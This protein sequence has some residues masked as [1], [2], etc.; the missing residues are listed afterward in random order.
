MMLYSQHLNVAH[1][2]G[3]GFTNW[4]ERQTK[5][6][7]KGNPQH[8]PAFQTSDCFFLIRPIGDTCSLYINITNF[9]FYC[10]VASDPK[11]VHHNVLVKGQNDDCPNFKKP[12]SRSTCTIFLYD[13]SKY[14][15]EERSDELFFL[16]K[17]QRFNGFISH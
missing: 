13:M 5:T 12:C 1:L 14:Y 17:W 2:L 10:I 15:F 11:C 9:L 3:P 4:E 16:L 6:K 7:H 8:F